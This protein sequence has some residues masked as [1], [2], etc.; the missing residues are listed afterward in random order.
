MKA[1][2]FSQSRMDRCA[3][4]AVS[5]IDNWRRTNFFD[6]TIR[7]TDSVDGISLDELRKRYFGVG[8]GENLVEIP[9]TDLLVVLSIL[10]KDYEAIQRSKDK[11]AKASTFKIKVRVKTV[12]SDDEVLRLFS[13]VRIQTPFDNGKT[14]RLAA[15]S[16]RPPTS[17]PEG[18]DSRTEQ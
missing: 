5:I 4:I 12:F 14:L 3:K 18:T 11:I 15:D 7:A 8:V 17:D 1:E 9:F 13:G 2:R 10:K 6:Y 16:G